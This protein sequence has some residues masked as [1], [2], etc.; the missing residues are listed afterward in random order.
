MDPDTNSENPKPQRKIYNKWLFSLGLVVLSCAYIFLL[1][2][3]N[4]RRHRQLNQEA[5]ELEHKIATVDNLTEN[6]YSYEE[7]SEDSKRMEQY[8]REN[9]NMQRPEEDA[10]VIE[11][12]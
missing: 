9:L 10:F 6:D 1:S 3:S 7:I 2:D 12:K 4:F 5:K 11:Y 8:V